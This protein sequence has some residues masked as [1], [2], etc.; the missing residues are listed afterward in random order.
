MAFALFLGSPDLNIPLPT[1]TPSAPSCIISAASAGVATPPAEKLGTGSLRH[2]AQQRCY[3]SSASHSTHC[4]VPSSPWRLA[5]VRGRPN[6]H[7]ASQLPHR[8]PGRTTAAGSRHTRVLRRGRVCAA[9]RRRGRGRGP[10]GPGR[11]R[12]LHRRRLQDHAGDGRGLAVQKR[13]D[14]RL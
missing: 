9:K 14:A 4:W 10:L 1:N 13:I 6:P 2:E 12:L 5:G 11:A 3:C 7:R 8:E